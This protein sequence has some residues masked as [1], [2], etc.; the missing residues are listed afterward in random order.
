MFFLS[1]MAPEQIVSYRRELNRAIRVQEQQ[2][3]HQPPPSAVV[4]SSPIH[5]PPPDPTSSAGNSSQAALVARFESQTRLKPE[6]ALKCLA[7]N[8]FNYDAALAAFTALRA[9]V[10]H[11]AFQ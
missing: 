11:E 10:P 9:A 8:Q 4:D 2:A 3:A 1:G 5:H 7:E 6:W